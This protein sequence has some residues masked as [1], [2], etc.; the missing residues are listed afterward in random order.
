MNV[1]KIIGAMALSLA[2]TSPVFATT[3]ETFDSAMAAYHRQ[4]YSTAI[5]LMERVLPDAGDSATP[6]AV[7]GDSCRNLGNLDCA[8]IN[9][10]RAYQLGSREFVVL[11]GLGY[12][13][14]DMGDYQ[15][16]YTYLNEAANKYPDNADIFWNL[17]LVCDSLGNDFYT[18][19]AMDKT[20]R[21]APNKSP[22]PYLYA[23]LICVNNG[24]IE[25]GLQYYEAG[26]QYFNDPELLYGAADIYNYAGDYERAAAYS[27]QA[28]RLIPDY[29]D[30]W[31]IYGL[32]KLAL[33]DLNAGLDACDVM[34]KINS[35]DGRTKEVCNSAQQKQTI[36]Q[37]EEMQR[38]QQIQ[39]QIDMDMQQQQQDLDQQMMSN[40]GMIY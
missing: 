1:K 37:M 32:S 26:L 30:A 28:I 2:L 29:F 36:R 14:M 39:D 40:N 25:K 19:A 31:Y 11:S 6:Y 15:S 23:A 13:Y 12:A 21:L 5:S 18:L 9:L 8:V 38:Q 20:I 34:C 35:E 22:K 16:A 17:G 7:I 27:E 24:N 33:E 10:G 3:Q 4:D